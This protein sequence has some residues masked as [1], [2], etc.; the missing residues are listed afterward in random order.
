MPQGDAMSVRLERNISVWVAHLLTS[1]FFLSAA[2]THARF[3]SN[4][5]HRYNTLKSSAISGIQALVAPWR[6]PHISHDMIIHDKIPTTGFLGFCHRWFTPYINGGDPKCAALRTGIGL[7]VYLQVLKHGRVHS[8][9]LG[10]TSIATGCCLAGISGL[11][12]I[13]ELL[14][15]LSDYITNMYQLQGAY[16]H[17]R[18]YLHVLAEAKERHYLDAIAASLRVCYP[19]SHFVYPETIK[20]YRTFQ[21]LLLQNKVPGCTPETEKIFLERVYPVDNHV[22]IFSLEQRYCAALRVSA[23]PTREVT[24]YIDGISR[25]MISQLAN[26]NTLSQCLALQ[27]L[28]NEYEKLRTWGY[29]HEGLHNELERRSYVVIQDLTRGLKQLQSHKVKEFLDLIISAQVSGHL[30][31]FIVTMCIDHLKD[32][33]SFDHIDALKHLSRRTE[34][35]TRQNH[36]CLLSQYVRMRLIPNIESGS[37]QLPYHIQNMIEDSQA[38]K[39]ILQETVTWWRECNR[40][41]ENEKMCAEMR[42]I[43]NLIKKQNGKDHNK[44]DLVVRMV[45]AIRAEKDN[46]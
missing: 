12:W 9:C 20:D 27:S 17:N 19:I 28:S 4:F 32:L 40:V 44:N 42:N 1:S 39:D 45:H 2:F 43:F 6:N 34:E 10:P 18:Q 22:S 36:T 14:G 46:Q 5:A 16:E 33:D 29:Q 3:M 13:N 37:A 41:S 38:D 15:P 24:T 11:L 26:N 23:L 35:C 30:L 31:D 7:A 21:E 25:V 8:T